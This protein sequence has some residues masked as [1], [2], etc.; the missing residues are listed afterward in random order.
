MR[1]LYDCHSET[2]MPDKD[3]DIR[4]QILHS[5]KL[6]SRATIV[7]YLSVVLVAGLGFWSAQQQRKA[8]ARETEK[9]VMALCTFRA[10]LQRRYEAGVDFLR[11]NPD[12]IPGITAEDL[13]RSL[14]NQKSTL[15]ALEGLP[16]QK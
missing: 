16:C 1:G 12:G 10:D 6:L 15:D 9:T 8:L 7:L 4:A 13:Q 3:P 2:D 11:E 5:I 14:D